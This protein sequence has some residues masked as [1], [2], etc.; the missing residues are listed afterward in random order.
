M[1]KKSSVWKI[2]S[3]EILDQHGAGEEGRD[4]AEQT[5]QPIL[6]AAQED[7]VEARIELHGQ[8]ARRNLT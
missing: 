4:Q 1:E 6:P 5:G 2:D 8:Q 7:Q 3:S